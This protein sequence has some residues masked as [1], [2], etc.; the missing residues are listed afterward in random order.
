MR[1]MRERKWKRKEGR[2]WNVMKER[3]EMKSN[4][5]NKKEMERQAW[6]GKIQERNK[7]NE[8]CCRFWL[9]KRNANITKGKMKKKRF[10]LFVQVHSL[11]ITLRANGF[12]VRNNS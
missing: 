6:K 9:K 5:K 12:I 7:E 8:R 4:D 1:L 10:P 2:K 3:K 11:Y